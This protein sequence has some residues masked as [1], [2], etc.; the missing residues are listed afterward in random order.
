MAALDDDIKPKLLKQVQATRQYS[1][2]SM[3]SRVTLRA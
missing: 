1:S 3:N 2:R